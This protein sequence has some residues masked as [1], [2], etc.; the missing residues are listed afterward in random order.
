MAWYV[1]GLRA[2]SQ[3]LGECLLILVTV[4]MHYQGFPRLLGRMDE[5]AASLDE[6]VIMQAG[7]TRFHA[8]HAQSFPFTSRKAEME[9]LVV[10]S[11]LVV[12]HGGVASIMLALHHGKPVIAVPRLQRFEEHHDDHQM[13][14]VQA[15]AKEGRI[16]A[17]YDIDE[18]TEAVRSQLMP[19]AGM[20]EK[21]IQPI[22]P[23]P[24]LV[25]N[26]RGY[27]HSLGKGV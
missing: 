22:G 25:D 10:R 8:S 5:I 26:L 24:M 9:E 2:E 1:A 18:L 19:N 14:V 13:E 20:P 11:R 23:T 3:V 21:P 27:F 7:H 16:I 15:L 12:C 4:G 17:V 6:E